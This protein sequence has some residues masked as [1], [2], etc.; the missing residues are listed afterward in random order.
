M[1]RKSVSRADISLESLL[2]GVDPLH[3]S[4]MIMGGI[5]A[6]SGLKPPLTQLL[7][8]LNS[9]A[10][11]DVWHNISTP[12]YK[13]LGEWMSGSDSTP[14]PELR[15]EAVAYFCAGAME[16]AIMYQLVSNPET[17]KELLKMPGQV[18]GGLGSIVP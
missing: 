16:A 13:L 8:A 18:M 2:K 9:G 1:T 7:I 5:A 15:N 17:F 6:A 14:D 11:G 4:V 10:A 12:G 3:A